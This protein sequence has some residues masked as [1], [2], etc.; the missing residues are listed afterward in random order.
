MQAAGEVHA[1]MTDHV[2]SETTLSAMVKCAD[3]RRIGYFIAYQALVSYSALY[4]VV[5]CLPRIFD[6]EKYAIAGTGA[7]GA[8]RRFFPS[9]RCVGTSVA[10]RRAQLRGLQALE[11]RIK[12]RA[13]QLFGRDAKQWDLQSAEHTPCEFFKWRLGVVH[14]AGVFNVKL[15]V[16]VA[17]GGKRPRRMRRS[18][19]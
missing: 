11:A 16:K 8:L 4:A 6:K 3:L 5:P 2:V 10:A 12:P 1:R 15:K 19:S 14:F 18:M 13:R 7:T 17:G 9:L